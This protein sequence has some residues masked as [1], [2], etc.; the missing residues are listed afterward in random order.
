MYTHPGY[1]EERIR[2]GY[3]SA[4]DDI[5]VFADNIFS[6]YYHYSFTVSS[7]ER[8]DAIL[9]DIFQKASNLNEAPIS[10]EI[11]SSDANRQQEEGQEPSGEPNMQPV[12]EDIARLDNFNA[13]GSESNTE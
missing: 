2:S 12:Q 3:L 1:I 7:A 8:Y 4:D 6:I 11:F 9:V 10:W 5:I 13:L